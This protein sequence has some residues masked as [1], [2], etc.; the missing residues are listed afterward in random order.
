MNN[1]RLKERLIIALVLFFSNAILSQH[2]NDQIS[3]YI[4]ALSTLWEQHHRVTFQSLIV[5]SSFTLKAD[6]FRIRETSGTEEYRRL[7]LRANKLQQRINSR[8]PGLHAVL[9]YQEN[10]NTPL[11]D[12]EDLIIFKRRAVAGVDWDL[13]NNGLY[14]NRV[15]NKILQAEYQALEQRTLRNDV[16][17]FE[18]RNIEQIIRYFNKKKI[19]ILDA[20]KTLNEQQSAI[21][22]KLWSVKHITKD[23]Y[24]KVVQNTTDI[25]AQY[26]IYKNYNDVPSSESREYDFELPVLDIDPDELFSKAQAGTT[27]T[28]MESGY[29]SKPAAEYLRDVSLKAYTRYNYYYLINTAQSNRSYVSVGMN[30]SMPLSFNQKDKR[31]YLALQQQLAATKPGAME[32]D[33]QAVLLNHYYEYQYTLKQFK[34]FYHKHL[35]FTELLRTERV[36]QQLGDVE[37]NP[38]HALFILDDYWSNMIELLDLKQKMYRILLSVK[39]KLPD[40]PVTAYTRILNLDNLEISSSRPPFKAVY[41]WSDAFRNNSPDFISEYC[42]L[43]EFN[44]VLVSYNPSKAH[45]QQVKLLLEKNRLADIHVMIGSNRLFNTGISGFLDTLKNNLDLSLIKGIHLDIEPHTLDGFKENKVAFFTKYMD[46]LKQAK[47]FAQSHG[48]SFSVSIP[49]SYPTNVL[50]EINACC[51]EVYLMAY[52][53]TDADFILKKTEEEKRILKDKCVLALRTKDFKNRTDMDL[54][55]KKTGFEKTAYHDLDDLIKFDY[56]SINR[57]GER[58]EER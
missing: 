28:A 22:E 27:D 46:L 44:P 52:E 10:L 45:V 32:P 9:S 3:A 56:T 18:S 11:F 24:L 14:E 6:P 33:L 15:K 38:N 8:N 54:F 4:K 41:V 16:N 5:D 39:L 13:L 29:R 55:F 49:L 19:S 30:L 42:A 36:K 1:R 31:E 35:V 47:R 21:N 25:R 20:R 48:L 23:D 40:V 51:D 12:P 7:L 2:Q 50:E 34:N 37:F 57:E 58:Y 43:N 26:N 53:H 17:A